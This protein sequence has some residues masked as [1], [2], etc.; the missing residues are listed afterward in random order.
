MP[1]SVGARGWHRKRTER[2]VNIRRLVGWTLAAITAAL[3]G[4]HSTTTTFCASDS[5][6]VAGTYCLNNSCTG[7]C[8]ESSCPD[9]SQCVSGRCYLDSCPS[10]PCAMGDVCAN[11]VCQSPACVTATC[12]SSQACVQGQCYAIACGHRTCLNGRVCD[13]NVC[14]DPRCIGVSCTAPQACVAGTCKVPSCTDGIQDGT[15]TDIDCGGSCPPCTDGRG[16]LKNS[17]CTSNACVQSV[18]SEPS[19]TDGIQDGNETDV[20]CGGGACPPCALGKHCKVSS[21]CTSVFCSAGT[22]EPVIQ[23]LTAI[24]AANCGT[25]TTIEDVFTDCNDQPSCTYTLNYSVDPGYDPAPGC[26]KD[27][28]VTWTCNDGK[29]THKLYFPGEADGAVVNLA[30]P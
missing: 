23:V 14:T 8:P 5:D 3:P 12:T 29:P 7:A 2:P 6:C 28:T 20:D 17:D 24:Y 1:R 4:C 18:C 10:G 15:E 21:D 30:C 25:P 16:C 13:Q 22:C 19:C 11:D 26:A 27:L 9:A